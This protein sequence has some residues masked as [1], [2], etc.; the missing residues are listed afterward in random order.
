MEVRGIDMWLYRRIV[1]HVVFES[2]ESRI[3][4]DLVFCIIEKKNLGSHRFFSLKIV[5]MYRII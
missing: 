2:E 3:N 4:L 1:S 5:N